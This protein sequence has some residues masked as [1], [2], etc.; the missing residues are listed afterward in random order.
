MNTIEPAYGGL[1]FALLGAFFISYSVFALIQISFLFSRSYLRYSLVII[2]QLAAVAGL[3]AAD[4]SA[5]CSSQNSHLV[6][7]N[8][9]AGLT[10]LAVMWLNVSFSMAGCFMLSRMIKH[11]KTRR[12]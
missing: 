9:A 10:G 11:Y 8:N 1:D 3:R 6:C 5:L 2:I 4:F 12:N 7:N